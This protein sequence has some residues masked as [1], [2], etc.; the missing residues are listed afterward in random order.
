MK[1]IKVVVKKMDR[2][3]RKMAIYHFMKKMER[4]IFVLSVITCS[5]PQNDCLNFIFVKYIK[6]VVKKMAINGLKI[7]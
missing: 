1:D 4:E 3:S 7:Q 5:A 2:N 6:V